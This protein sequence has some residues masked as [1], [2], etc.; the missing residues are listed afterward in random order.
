[1]EL[2]QLKAKKRSRDLKTDR[3]GAKVPEKRAK[4]ALDEIIEEE[5]RRGKFRKVS[6]KVLQESPIEQQSKD[7]WLH[8]NVVV[9]VMHKNLSDGKYYKKKVWLKVLLL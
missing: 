3:P 4:S 2:P 7:Y 8:E 6:D 1:M 5:S 9:K